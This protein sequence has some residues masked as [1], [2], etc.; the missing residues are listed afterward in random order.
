MDGPVLPGADRAG[1]VPREPF[2]RRMSPLAFAVFALAVIFLLYQGVGGVIA[3][4]LISGRPTEANVSLTRWV[5]VGGQ[6]ILILLP[7]LWLVHR[8]HGKFRPFLRLH[9][10]EVR[11]LFSTMV[12]VFALQQILQAYMIVQDSIPLPPDIQRVVDIF[13]NAIE[14]AYRLLV[15]A[16]SPVEFLVVLFV[17]AVVPAVTE[18][19]LFRGLVQRNLEQAAGGMRGAILAGVIFG[20][21]HLNPFDIVPLM[22]LGIYLG[23]IVYRSGNITLAIS[24]HFFNN[25]VAC[26]AVYLQLN[27]DFVALAPESHPT[28][29]LAMANLAVFLMVFLGATLYFIKITAR[30]EDDEG[31]S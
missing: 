6:L 16:R 22:A 20:A 12:G 8:R 2:L 19:L 26:T 3:L 7:T 11:E 10:P 14:Q 1:S 13:R 28:V 29:S 15:Q 23:Y 17:A 5:T 27:D 9:L 31:L 25:F 4:V 21:Y 18:E 24:A 30:E